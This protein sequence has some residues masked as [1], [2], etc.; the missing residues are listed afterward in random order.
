VW[1]EIQSLFGTIKTAPEVWLMAIV[2][3]TGAGL[4]I[5]VIL[6]QLAQQDPETVAIFNATQGNDTEV[7]VY[8]YIAAIVLYIGSTIMKLAKLNKEEK[9]DAS[10][11]D[12]AD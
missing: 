4:P 11:Q 1:K 12:N 9:E 7:S 10:I 6:V 8:S 3:L 5:D 2:I